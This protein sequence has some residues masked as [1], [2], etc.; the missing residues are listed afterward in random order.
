MLK[1]FGKEFTKLKIQ[2]HRHFEFEKHS[3]IESGNEE[4][5][6]FIDRGRS[7]GSKFVRSRSNP[8][9]FRRARSQSWNNARSQSR[10]RVNQT[11]QKMPGTNYW[12]NKN[13][14][15]KC[16]K[17]DDDKF[18]Q[19]MKGITKISESY[20]DLAK[21]VTNLEDKLKNVNYC[22]EEIC[23]VHFAEKDKVDHEIIID[24]GCP[25]TLSGE[26]LINSYVKKHNLDF[27]KLK[28]NPCATIFKFGDSR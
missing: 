24:S 11:F 8:R 15:H 6:H 20:E 12:N 18:S 26:R 1:D 14:P 13:D 4:S 27:T 5:V 9:F 28:R 3:S 17:D 16:G 2:N 21:K 22:E 25:K 7:G 19:I 23:E 10:S